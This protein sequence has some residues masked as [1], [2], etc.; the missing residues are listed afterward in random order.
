MVRTRATSASDHQQPQQTPAAIS[1]PQPGPSANPTLSTSM[2]ASSLSQGRG[3][4]VPLISA[5]EERMR[6]L[7]TR[8]LQDHTRASEARA[9]EG[10]IELLENRAEERFS[11][12]ESEIRGMS[13][14]LDTFLRQM[15]LNQR[16]DAPQPAPVQ[17]SQPPPWIRQGILRSNNGTQF[18]SVD[19]IPQS[20]ENYLP[21][22]NNRGPHTDPPRTH[23]PTEEPQVNIND[24]VRPNDASNHSNPL[25]DF[26]TYKPIPLKDWG[27]TFSGE[28]RGTHVRTFL[29]EIE[30]MATAQRVS[31]ASVLSSIHLCLS[32]DALRWYRSCELF[33]TWDDF[34]RSIKITFDR[35]DCDLS[36]RR[37]LEQ[38]KQRDGERVGVYVADLRSLFRELETPLDEKTMVQMVRRNLNHRIRES[39]L[40]RE[41]ATLTELEDAL[42]ISENNMLISGDDAQPKQKRVS[43]I[44]QTTNSNAS[45]GNR[46]GNNNRGNNRR[47]TQNSARRRPSLCVNCFLGNHAVNDCTQPRRANVLCYGCGAEGVI[48]RN[49]P[50]CSGE[51]SPGQ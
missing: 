34:S 11:S 19:S 1:T 39:I 18:L 29:R 7:E 37:R 10:R 21:P 25:R 12:L 2:N 24:N 4:G 9:M 14:L 36:V 49:C 50:S 17:Q 41:F 27:I 38:R 42:R 16:E 20:E 30:R 48:K 45:S 43:A 33:G 51:G 47:F 35:F 3:R 13:S 40:L 23:P 6:A 44:E 31:L 28:I 22:L 32:G 26:A 15:S 8:D 5:L 46:S